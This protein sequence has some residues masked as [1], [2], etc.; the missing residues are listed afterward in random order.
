MHG[1]DHR[2]RRA[3]PHQRS[4]LAGLPAAQLTER[5]VRGEAELA[6]LGV[7]P[8]VFI[9]PYNRFDASQYAVLA[10]RYDVVCGGPES[11]MRLGFQRTPLWRGPAIYL[12]AYAPLYGEAAAV[13]AGVEA[14]LD[15]QA[16]IWAPLVLHW[17]HEAKA[18]WTALERL[19]E[20]IGPYARPWGEFLTGVEASR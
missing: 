4:E 7:R 6:S 20:L 3:L 18:G 19:A 12:P 15:A 9:A 16:A 17:G 2:T 13:K 10:E 1:L 11:V 8:R 14:L 5:L